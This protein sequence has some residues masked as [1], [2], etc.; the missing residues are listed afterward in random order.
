MEIKFLHYNGA[1][2]DHF[3]PYPA[4]KAPPDWFKKL[5]QTVSSVD[6]TIATAKNCIPLQDV[7]SA[8][9]II[10]NS[11]EIDLKTK[12]ISSEEFD[13]EMHKPKAANVG[14][15][16][17]DQCPMHNNNGKINYFKLYL[18]WQIRTPPGYSCLFVDPFLREHRPYQILPAIVDTDVYDVP[19]NF[20]GQLNSHEITTIAPGEPIVQV[21]PFRR[22]DWKMSAELVQEPKFGL[23][24]FFNN[25][26]AHPRRIYKTLAHKKKKFD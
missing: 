17:Y 23:F 25:V 14:F 11:F 5:P 19:I 12:Q 9:Y 1:V 8:G 20:I 7:V 4:K 15:H 26:T 10:P 18:D 6:K 21:I 13:I 22:D 16:H 24:D 2:V 3:S